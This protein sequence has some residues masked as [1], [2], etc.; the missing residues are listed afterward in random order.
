MYWCGVI[1]H[2]ITFLQE[3]PITLSQDYFTLKEKLIDTAG[4][5]DSEKLT[6]PSDN[7]TIKID[8][9]FVSKDLKVKGAIVPDLVS[10]DHRPIIADIEF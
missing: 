10:S 3:K 6:F 5:I 7:P 1:K 4:F 2:K 9:I 8:Y